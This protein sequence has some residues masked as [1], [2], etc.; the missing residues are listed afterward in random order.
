ML[1]LMKVKL[2]LYNKDLAFQF[3]I[4]P[5]AVSQWASAK[6]LQDISKMRINHWIYQ[7]LIERSF[8]LNARV[9]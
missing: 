6:K 1:M 3:K 5:V 8:N 2:G 4:K 9:R 7:I